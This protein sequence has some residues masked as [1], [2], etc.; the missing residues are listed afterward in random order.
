MRYDFDLG[1]RVTKNYEDKLNSK[2]Y[3]ESKMPYDIWV[4][5]WSQIIEHAAS[6]IYM[7]TED[8]G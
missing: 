2:T 7:A 3:I 8:E 5:S 6:M 1:R 4:S